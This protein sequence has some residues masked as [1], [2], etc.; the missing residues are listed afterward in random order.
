MMDV[1]HFKPLLLAK[2]EAL[3][4]VQ[5]TGREAAETVVLDQTSVGRL[6]RMDAMQDQAMAIATAKRREHDLLM[7]ESAL[8][9]LAAGDYGVCRGCEETI[10]EPRLNYDPAVVYCLKCAAEI[11]SNQ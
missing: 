6:S 3:I 1:A 5:K 11:E 2:R 8:L 4:E 7:I 10:A 9:R